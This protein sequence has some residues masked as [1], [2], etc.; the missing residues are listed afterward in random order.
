MRPVSLSSSYLAREPF[1]I[2]TNTSTPRRAGLPGIAP[3]S[4]VDATEDK[5]R[6]GADAHGAGRRRDDDGDLAL[7]CLFGEAWGE[8]GGRAA[9][10]LL[11]QLRE[12][13]GNGDASLGRDR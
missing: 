10:D 13:A 4:R 1:G 8:L 7:R 2:S 3:P 6:L 5:P 11:V 9:D 12:L